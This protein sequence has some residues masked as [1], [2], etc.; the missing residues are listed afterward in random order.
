MKNKDLSIK[1]F[2]ELDTN[3]PFKVGVHPLKLGFHWFVSCACLSIRLI[4]CTDPIATTVE[5]KSDSW[6][7][8][9]SEIQEACYK[10][11]LYPAHTTFLLEWYDL[12]AIVAYI[13]ASACWIGKGC[14]V[15]FVKQVCNSCTRKLVGLVMTCS[16][17]YPE[18]EVHA[19]Q[20]CYF[21]SGRRD[22]L[23]YSVVRVNTWKLRFCN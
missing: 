10:H 9:L 23:P 1:V 15:P 4:C 6:I 22:R 12:F 14:T 8:H 21:P 18:T 19:P 11:K 17:H 2:S 7:A 16:R 13:L 20:S 5:R 3:H